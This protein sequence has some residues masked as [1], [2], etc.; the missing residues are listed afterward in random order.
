VLDSEWE[1]ELA[2]VLEAHPQVISYAK[3]QGMQFE[4]PYRIGRTVRRYIPDFLVRVDIGS[5]EPL[6]LVL[7]TKGYRG[8]DA[9]LKA[10]TMET[11]W[12]PSVNNIQ[13]YGLWGF[14]EF[15][16]VFSIQEEF[17]R[18]LDGVTAKETA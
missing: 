10:M 6:N 1:A 14:A 16:E 12:V 8:L 9:Q 17:G 15:R 11:L 5:A 3:N 4:I 7:E 13:T 2:R 18:L